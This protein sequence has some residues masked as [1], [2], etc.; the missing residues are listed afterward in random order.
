MGSGWVRTRVSVRARF[1]V[2]DPVREGLVLVFGFKLQFA[3]SSVSVSVTV[4]VR[5]P[6]R[7]L[8]EFVCVVRVMCVD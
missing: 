7:A 4:G 3:L 1:Q 8:F 2:G 6:F 5:I